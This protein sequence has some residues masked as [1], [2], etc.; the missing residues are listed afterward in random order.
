MHEAMNATL[1]AQY[2]VEA[3]LELP[4]SHPYVWCQ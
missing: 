4:F 2:I 1:Y 3:A